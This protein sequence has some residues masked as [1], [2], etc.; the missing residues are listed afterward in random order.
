MHK[1]LEKVYQKLLKS[2]LQAIWSCTAR[3]IRENIV[4]AGGPLQPTA[5]ADSARSALRETVL[6]AIQ[7]PD[8]VITDW[9]ATVPGGVNQSLRSQLAEHDQRLTAGQIAALRDIGD[10]VVVRQP[11][12]VQWDS[13]ST[14]VA[15]Y[16]RLVRVSS[17]A[18]IYVCAGEHCTR[19]A[20]AQIECPADHAHV[21]QYRCSS[22][23]K[24]RWRTRKSSLPTPRPSAR[25]NNRPHLGP[26][27]RGRSNETHCA[28]D[29]PTPIPCCTLKTYVLPPELPV[30]HPPTSHTRMP[31]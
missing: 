4:S 16:K 9:L 28:S 12:E 31:P 7:S 25:S 24:W 26:S 15:V 23:L 8:L 27:R 21:Y 14:R 2:L 29:S 1:S 20:P 17:V 5:D 10:L 3:Y 18:Y 22:R 19:Q 13:L 30:S 11:E 6:Q